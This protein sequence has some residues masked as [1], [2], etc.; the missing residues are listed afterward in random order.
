MQGN[1]LVLLPE[2]LPDTQLT[3]LRPSLF[4]GGK[5]S[6]RE[7]I[8]KDAIG[9]TTGEREATYGPVE[10]NLKNC[11]ALVTAYLEGKY[12]A[13]SPTL[14]SEDIAWVMVLI[15]MVR[16]FHNDMHEDNYVDAAAYAAIAAQCRVYE[17]C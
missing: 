12:G 7:T 14:T 17:D 1:I 4:F 3:G 16:T 11:A 15:K 5:M 13:D 2:Y 8:L 10:N 6:I 9:L